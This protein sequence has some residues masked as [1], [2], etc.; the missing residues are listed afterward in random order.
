M[1]IIHLDSQAEKQLPVLEKKLGKV[2]GPKIWTKSNARC[3]ETRLLLGVKLQTERA[4]VD[5]WSFYRKHAKHRSPG[6]WPKGYNGFH[7]SLGTT[8]GW[9]RSKGCIWKGSNNFY[10]NLLWHF[11]FVIIKLASKKYIKYIVHLGTCIWKKNQF[12]Q[13]F[14]FFWLVQNNKDFCFIPA[15]GVRVWN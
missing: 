8:L 13:N 7:I 10:P 1:F 15:R 11:R 14:I 9:I 3:W 5:F 12:N 2:F 6:Y 4:T